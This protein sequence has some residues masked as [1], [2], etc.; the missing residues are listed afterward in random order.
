[1]S[2]DTESNPGMPFQRQTG[3][4][5][6]RGAGGGST[7]EPASFDELKSAQRHALSLNIPSSLSAVRRKPFLP[8]I[9]TRI[10]EGNTT[11]GDEKDTEESESSLSHIPGPESRAGK[12]G[13][14]LTGES[15]F[16]AP[17]H[18]S[19]RIH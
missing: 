7:T 10:K 11:M 3:V 2:L 5:R 8:I 13:R 15:Q 12:S 19:P 14:S 6:D 9:D 16:S 18:C 4:P 1:M 17:T